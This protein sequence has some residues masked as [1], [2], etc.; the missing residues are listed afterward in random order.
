MLLLPWALAAVLTA[1]GGRASVPRPALTLAVGASDLAA[2]PSLL[3]LQVPRTTIHASRLPAAGALLLLEQGTVPAAVLPGALAAE[4]HAAVAVAALV[5]ARTDAV[6]LWTAR[7]VFHWGDLSHQVVFERGGDPEALALLLAA[8]QDAVTAPPSLV[9]GTP[10]AA[11]R[12]PPGFL[13]VSEPYAAELVRQGRF[14]RAVLPGAELG[15]Y[16]A[17]VLAVGRRF[18][19]AHPLLVTALVAA[20]ARNEE[21]LC[22]LPLPTLVQELRPSFPS[23]SPSALES[24]LALMRRLGLFPASP[25]ASPL[26]ERLAQLDPSGPWRR[27]RVE[28]RWAEQG[29]LQAAWR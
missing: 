29:W 3:P 5:A 7:G 4:A 13:W 12:Q 18:A 27:A 24:A 20:L 19:A 17:L 11:L 9:P 14:R 28:D 1:C 22:E 25:L 21:E 23:V 6:L 8:Y 15:P 26:Y 16:P 2:A 10:A